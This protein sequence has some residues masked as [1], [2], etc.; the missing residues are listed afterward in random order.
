MRSNADAGGRPPPPSTSSTVRL[1]RSYLP[2]SFSCRSLLAALIGLPLDRRAAQGHRPEPALGLRRLRLAGAGLPAGWADVACSGSNRSTIDACLLSSCS[3][4]CSGSRW[5]ITSSCS[6]A[7]QG[8]TTAGDSTRGGRRRGIPAGRL[9]TSAAS[10]WSPSS[11][12]SL[13]LDRP[14]QQF[15]FGL[16]AAV[17]L[18]ATI[19][20]MVLVPASMSLLG[21]RNWYLPAWLDQLSF[22]TES[23]YRKPLR[24]RSTPLIQSAKPP[25]QVPFTCGRP[26]ERGGRPSFQGAVIDTSHA[27]DGI[28]SPSWSLP[29]ACRRGPE[30]SCAAAASRPKSPPG[31][32]AG[33]APALG[34]V[35]WVVQRTIAWLHQYRRSRIRYAMLRRH[36]L[37]FPGYSAAA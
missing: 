27:T 19:V 22:D 36:P 32:K 15:G 29:G 14:T 26:A 1:S 31:R 17:F 7:S 21:K 20:R 4:S 25:S 28:V 37:S 12:A 30:K 6:A 9:I 23:S 3:A 16:A 24:S 33:A 8:T 35:F 11:R 18:D 2:S 5:T 10:S 34:N 13:R